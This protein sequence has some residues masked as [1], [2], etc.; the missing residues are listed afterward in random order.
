MTPDTKSQRR[1]WPGVALQLVGCAICIICQSTLAQD[2]R[3]VTI[4]AS[5]CRAL[6]SP[7]ERL[8]CFEA[9]VDAAI[10]GEG[11][12]SDSPAPAPAPAAAS[13]PPQGSQ[14]SVPTVDITDLPRQDIS[15]DAPRQSELVGNIT[16]LR[17]RAPSQYLITLDNGQVWQQRFAERYPLRVGQRV[18]IYQGK[19]GSGLRLQV[20]GLNGFIQV[21]RVQ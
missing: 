14:P 8:A 17:A 3:D 9:Q 10:T 11:R 12:E 13:V 1:R 20:E 6:E 4:D 21:D 16:S 5:R 15:A 19:F 2:S 18:R 7:D